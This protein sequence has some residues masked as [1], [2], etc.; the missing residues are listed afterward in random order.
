[1]QEPKTLEETYDQCTAEGALVELAI[2]NTQRLKDY[3]ANAEINIDSAITLMK[4]LE[5]QDKKWMSVYIHYYEALR[6]Y[7]EVLKIIDGKKALNHQCLFAALCIN[8]PEL[9][10]NWDFFEKIRTKRNGANYY[11]D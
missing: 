4:G 6:I 3:M 5:K 9:E 7:S 10:L 2:E 11:G 8:H 1:M